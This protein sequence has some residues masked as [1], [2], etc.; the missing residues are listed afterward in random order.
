MY[1]VLILISG[2]IEEE[3]RET[4]PLSY[5]RGNYLNKVLSVGPRLRKT[6]DE[7]EE[8]Q[9]GR[10]ATC[11]YIWPSEQDAGIVRIYIRIIMYTR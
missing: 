5:P 9:R 8:E 7:E 6:T 2:I 3:T 10:S 1:A 4:A 11:V